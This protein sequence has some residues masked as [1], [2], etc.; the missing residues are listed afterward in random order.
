LS[1]ALLRCSDLVFEKLG[2]GDS[3]NVLTFD[4]PKEHFSKIVASLFISYVLN[5]EYLL[6]EFHQMLRPG[7]FI[8]LSSMKPDSD[9]SMMFTNYIRKA[10]TP[11]CAEDGTIAGESGV[12]DARAMLNEAASL[13]ELEEDGFFRFYTPEELRDMLAATGFVDI[14]ILPSMG[15]PPQAYIAVGRKRLTL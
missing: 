12:E 2:F 10:Q 13:F 8:L 14:S 1:S 6:S 15:S 3:G 4:F 7:G 5:P 9:I 11:G